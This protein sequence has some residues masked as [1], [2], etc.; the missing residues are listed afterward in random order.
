MGEFATPAELNAASEIVMEGSGDVVST[1]QASENTSL[2]G[3]TI[4]EI[5]DPSE[6]SEV[7]PAPS[8]SL[9]DKEVK[10]I[11]DPTEKPAIQPK[12]EEKPAEPDAVTK[13]TEHKTNLEKALNESRAKNK[14]LQFLI[15][16]KAAEQP[17]KAADT[18]TIV[19][20]DFKVLTKAEF[21][22]LKEESALEAIQYMH[23]LQGYKDATTAKQQAEAQEQA[24]KTDMN[25][26]I[27]D[28]L[29]QISI[30]V[31]GVYETAEVGQKLTD[32][33]IERGFDNEALSILSNPAT[34][35]MVPG[36]TKP[37]PLGKAAVAFV[38]F[39]N[40]TMTGNNPS[41][42]RAEIE[43]DVTAKVT[44]DL[45]QKFKNNPSGVGLDEVPSADNGAPKSWAPKTEAELRAISSKEREAYYEGR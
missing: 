41:Q 33:A 15:D 7:I 45:I 37:V 32:F 4:P 44:K 14:S 31:P 12:A 10:I 35:V 13:L 18:P 28:S 21:E 5:V 23:D 42:L 40:E 8:P 27:A 19:D 20:P 3:E 11:V 34:M 43:R 39:C 25:V 24:A 22:S 16:Q 26:L 36:A 38:K 6:S 1:T 9:E 17:V 29:E 2:F 30:A